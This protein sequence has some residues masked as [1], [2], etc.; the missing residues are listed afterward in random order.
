MCGGYRER[1]RGRGER[2]REKRAAERRSDGSR[3]SGGAGEGGGGYSERTR[4]ARDSICSHGLVLHRYKYLMRGGAKRD[5]LLKIKSFIQS[6]FEMWAAI[7][8][9][10]KHECRKTALLYKISK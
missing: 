6:G 10:G 1:Q 2:E 5:I 8:R 3:Q 4:S 9:S 7:R